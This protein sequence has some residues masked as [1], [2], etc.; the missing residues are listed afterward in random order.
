MTK[1]ETKTTK[2][3]TRVGSAAETRVAEHLAEAGYVILARNQ[4]T[5]FYEIDII[6]T[7]LDPS[8]APEIVFV[9]VKYRRNADFGGGAESITPDKQFRLRRA[10][11]AWLVRHPHY[12][13]LQPRLDV[14]VVEGEHSPFRLHHY[15]DA[16]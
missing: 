1:S 9:E 5:R 15:E 16:I 7:R 14:V 12:Q 10:A 8:G 13:S 11:E 3:T 2:N 4:R 6:A